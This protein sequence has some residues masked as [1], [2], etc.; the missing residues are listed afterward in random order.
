MTIIFIERL[1]VPSYMWLHFLT[2]ILI[3]NG[4]SELINKIDSLSVGHSEICDPTDVRTKL[5][6]YSSKNSLKLLTQNI[7]SIS[8]NMNSF[9]VLLNNIDT[10]LDFI[11]LTECWLPKQSHIPSLDGFS[12][13]VSTNPLNKSDGVVVYYNNSISGI[14]LSEPKISDASCVQISVNDDTVILAIYRPCAFHSAHNFILS[15][16]PILTCLKRFKNI[17]IIG[18]ININIRSLEPDSDIE[19]YLNTLAFH[20]LL[21]THTLPTRNLSCL[22][23]HS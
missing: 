22:D 23:H 11:I 15:L 5:Q 20:G 8:A 4:D 2:Q 3:F 13:Y 1:C 19:E 7:R 18:D 14:S 21:P 10:N 9:S 16:D 17:I 6:T 12:K